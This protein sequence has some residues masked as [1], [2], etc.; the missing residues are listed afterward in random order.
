VTSTSTPS[1]SPGTENTPSPK[2]ISSNAP[3]ACRSTAARASSR[4]IPPTLTS[5]IRTP[6]RISSSFPAY[7]TPTTM[8]K[9]TATSARAAFLRLR[10]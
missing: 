6:L 8:S 3:A 5:P 2:R 10:A 4:V 7:Q 1:L 9:I